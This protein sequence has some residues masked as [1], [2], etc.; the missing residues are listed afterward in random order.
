MM[1]RLL[2]LLTA[3]PV[4]GL[5]SD[6]NTSSIFR[7]TLIGLSPDPPVGGAS[8]RMTVQFENPG[9]EVTGGIATTSVTLNGLP[10][11]PSVEALCQNT[12]CPIVVGANDRSTSS[13]WPD[14]ITG[15]VVTKSVWTNEAGDQLLCLLTSVKV[16]SSQFRPNAKADN[17][18]IDSLYRDDISQKQVSALRWPANAYPWCPV[19][20]FWL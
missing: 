8:V 15:R 1:L 19:R 3:V 18:T 11:S 16:G 7:P 13:T 4:F 17:I 2:A 5:V 12:A 10:F 20:D 9:S 6:C 14:G